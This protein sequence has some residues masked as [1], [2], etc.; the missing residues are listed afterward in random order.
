[1]SLA[2]VSEMTDAAVL[3]FRL[4]R[5]DY[6]LLRTHEIPMA[7]YNKARDSYHKLTKATKADTKAAVQELYLS[8]KRQ[9]IAKLQELRAAAG[10]AMKKDLRVASAAI[11][12]AKEGADKARGA[13]VKETL[14]HNKRMLK[15][16]TEQAEHLEG[17]DEVA[18]VM[19]AAADAG[20]AAIAPATDDE[21]IGADGEEQMLATAD[22]DEQPGAAADTEPPASG[23]RSSTDQSAQRQRRQRQRRQRQRRQ[24]QRHQRQRSLNARYAPS[25]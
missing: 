10:Q 13:M 20:E 16:L 19:E 9:L 25:R 14:R 22:G 15:L 3:T 8:Q 24:R 2:P 6:Q 21:Q 4:S 18:K 11:T 7:D 17:V 5:W 23:A 1:M 12:A